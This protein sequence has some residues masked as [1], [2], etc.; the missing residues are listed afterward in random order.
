M[1][2]EH[3]NIEKQGQFINLSWPYADLYVS[4]EELKTPEVV[5]TLDHDSEHEHICESEGGTW[6]RIL[7]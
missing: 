4:P 5:T 2:T 7:S 1:N 3:L 6:L